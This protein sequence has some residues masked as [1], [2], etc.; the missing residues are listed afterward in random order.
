MAYADVFSPEALAVA[1]TRRTS[2]G[3][4]LTA[5][6]IEDDEPRLSDGSNL[7]VVEAVG[8][9]VGFAHW[10]AASLVTPRPE[11]Y[12]FYVHPSSWGTGVAQLLWGGSVARF[13]SDAGARG[14]L[15][16]LAGA[17]RARA[18]YERQGWTPTGRA[19]LHDFDVGE[20]VTVVEY[21]SG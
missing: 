12:A 4:T 20:L 16:T 1:V 2:T 15:W 19:R 21:Q 13:P 14:V 3:T 10:G 11:V 9:V 18:F 5:R 6:L 17:V 7:L 8:R